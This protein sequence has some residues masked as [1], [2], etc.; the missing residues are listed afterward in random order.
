MSD[1]YDDFSVPESDFITFEEPGDSFTGVVR[2]LDSQLFQGD[3]EPKPQLIFD[4][5]K[6]LT[7]G[8]RNLLTQV[9]TER[10][11]IGDTVTVTFTGLQGRAKLF[12]LEI[13]RGGGGASNGGSTPE[14]SADN[15]LA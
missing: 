5:D 2:G 7:C 9:L 1:F 3:T 6:R 4:D 10:P 14:A 13:E 8:P 11:R 15:P 12:T